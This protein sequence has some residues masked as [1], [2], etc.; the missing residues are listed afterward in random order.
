MTTK[1]H[2]TTTQYV[3]GLGPCH[4]SDVFLWLP[5][6]PKRHFPSHH[7]TR[8]H[9]NTC[10]KLKYVELS[11]I[12]Q[13]SKNINFCIISRPLR[14]I[15]WP[16]LGTTG[17]IKLAPPKPVNGNRDG[18][19]TA[20]PVRFS[21][22]HSQSHRCVMFAAAQRNL[23]HSRPAGW[24]TQCRCCSHVHCYIHVLCGF[25]SCLQIKTKATSSICLSPWK[26]FLIHKNAFYNFKVY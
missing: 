5:V 19:I 24:T 17:L 4:V 6:P 22:V 14:F 16:L 8:F 7:L 1:T 23:S 13:K 10:S 20:V 15:L 12:L 25:L 2:K 18:V 3:S 9:M 21:V 11:N 26:I